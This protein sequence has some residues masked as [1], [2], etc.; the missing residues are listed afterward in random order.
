MTARGARQQREKIGWWLTY[1][2]T[3]LRHSGRVEPERVVTC[4]AYAVV[5]IVSA[6]NQ[7][8][9]LFGY[10]N[11]LNIYISIIVVL[12]IFILNVKLC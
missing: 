7:K 2:G 12:T 10:L 1:N 11:L 6:V 8:V 4:T 3:G 9:L 5:A